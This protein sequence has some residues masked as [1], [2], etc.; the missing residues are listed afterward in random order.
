[1]R[2]YLELTGAMV[3]VGSSVVAGI[4]ALNVL[5]SGAGEATG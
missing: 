4:V 1:M 2:A 3:L 5:G